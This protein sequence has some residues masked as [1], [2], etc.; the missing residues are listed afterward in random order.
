M[1]IFQPNGELLD[2]TIRAAN[3]K[4][5]VGRIHEVIDGASLDNDTYKT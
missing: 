2:Y 1:Q 3:A 5:V 4:S